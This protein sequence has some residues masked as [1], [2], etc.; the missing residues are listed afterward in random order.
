[1]TD[2][3]TLY[4][5]DSGTRNPDRNPRDDLPAHGH[6]W[7]GLGGIM[8]RDADQGSVEDAHR[9][10]CEKWNITYPLHSCEIRARIDSFHWLAK[11]KRKKLEAFWHDVG[12]LV[13]SAPIT[14]IA[15]VVDR[16][17]YNARYL[18]EY[19]R[20]RWTLCKTAFNVVVERAAK[21]ARRH[22]CRLRVCV[23]R[24][25]PGTDSRVQGYYEALRDTGQP[26]DKERSGKYSPLAPDDFAET[27]YEFR[28]K[29]KTSALMQIA[30]IALWP[31][32]IGGYDDKNKSFCA[33]QAA[34]TLINCRLREDEV[35]LEGIK[36]SCWDLQDARKDQSPDKS[37]LRGSAAY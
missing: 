30:D 23:E 27:L 26:F 11:L 9:A 35:G 5:D 6:D 16:P 2:V 36:Y 33:M 14:A 15:C 8:V 24:S 4:L 28:K 3:M 21:W 10:L 17:G 22:N 13:T 34:G 32:C 37:E 18:T 29:D 25:D 1:M 31:M 20:K 12:Q 7:F 19:G